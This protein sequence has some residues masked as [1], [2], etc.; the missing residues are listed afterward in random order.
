M[1]RRFKWGPVFFELNSELLNT[2]ASCSSSEDVVKAQE[3]W[4]EKLHH[5]SAKQEDLLGKES[6]TQLYKQ[7]RNSLWYLS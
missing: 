2:Y 6:C 3:D 4:L 1:L 7:L 5:E